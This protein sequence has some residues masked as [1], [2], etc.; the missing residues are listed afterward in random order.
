MPAK[1][2]ALMYISEVS[3]HHSATVA[4]ENAIKTLQPDAEILN[5]NA[6]NYTNPVS[7]K[8]VNR[9]YMGIIKRTPRIWDYLYDNPSVVKKIEKIKERIHRFNSPKFKRLFDQFQPDVV[10][11]TQAFPCGM[12]AGYKKNYNAEIPLVAVLTDYVPHS[13]WIY[14]EINYYIVPSDEVALRLYKKGIPLSKIKT[15]GIPFDLKFTK[16]ISRDE[17]INNLGLNPD[18]PTILIMGGGQGLGPIKTI[19]RVINKIKLEFQQIIVCGMN[20]KLY[21][22]LKKRGE[23]YRKKILL[24]GY[25]NNIDAL[26]S[27]AD[28]IITK[29]GGITTAEALSKKL[30]MIIVKPIP[31]QETNNT[32]YLTGQQAAIKVDNP[33]DVDLAIEDLLRNPDKLN[34]MRESASRIAKPHASLDIARLLLDLAP[35]AHV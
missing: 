19:V 32:A 1:R 10:A 20:K 4:I 2:I 18:I 23:K 35:K 6:F 7:E 9:I 5:I 31:G 21:R 11:C 22:A 17:M 16:D 13:Y 8:I 25:T 26:M 28:L 14:D 29:P 33:Q 15:L 12:V 24:F 3:G 30:P 27:V 34:R